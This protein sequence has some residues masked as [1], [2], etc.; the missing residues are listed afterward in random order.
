MKDHSAGKILLLLFGL[1]LLALL[2]HGYHA[3][4]EDDGVYLPAIQHDLN[5]GLYPHDSNFF[6]L[7]LQATLF[8]K[9]M[10]GSIRLSHLPTAV[11]VLGWHFLTIFWILWGCWRISRLCFPEWYA[12]WSAVCTVAALLTIPVAGTALYLVDQHLHPRA[13]ATAAIL[14]AI[15]AVLEKRLWLA[16]PL[17]AVACAFH[18]LMASFGI[19]YCAFLLWKPLERSTIAP[20]LAV[21]AA[22]PLDWVFEPTSPAWQQAAH[23]RDYFY[24]SAWHW[25][26]WIGVFA[27]LLLLWWFAR[28]GRSG[29]LPVLARMS[30]RLLFYGIFQ[31]AA[32]FVIALPPQ[33]DRLKPFQ[34]MRYLHLLYL[35]MFLF[36][37]GLVGQ[38]WLRTH[39]VRWLVLYVPLGVGMFL[40]QRQVFPASEH[41]EW[42]GAVPRNRWVQ[43]FLWVRGNTPTDSFFALDPYYMQ[44]PGEDAHSFRAWAERSVLADVVKD[45]S[46]ATQVPRLAPIWQQQVQAQTGWGQFQKADF[47]RLRTEFGVNW[48]I[49]EQ[50]GVVGLSCPYQNERVLVCRVE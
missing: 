23:T 42:P 40:A 45:A 27:P 30:S 41:V 50:P 19:S 37:G 2:V 31:L 1:S 34:P 13:L 49:V 11:V 43:S 20:A 4:V 6:T 8:D 7:Q 17:L 44:R 21:L 16:V 48:V 28:L 39:W 18:L 3:G 9:I 5:P 32:A 12:Q 25:Y 38:R 47:D 10:A 24:L 15:S 22:V 35:L 46:V 14:S 26:E 33:L 36:I 29:I